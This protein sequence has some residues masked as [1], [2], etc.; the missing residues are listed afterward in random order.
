MPEP[1]GLSASLI[2][3]V[4]DAIGLDTPSPAMA[5]GVAEL[6]QLFT[7]ERQ[8]LDGSYLEDD[9]LRLG[10]LSY[11]LPVN[12]AKVQSLLDE[13]PADAFD[14]FP[15]ERPLT[16]LDV[17]SG[18][19][20]AALGVLDWM[21]T[22]FGP[23]KKRLEVLA[24]DRSPLALRDCQGLWEAY[25]KI[26]PMLGSRL[27]PVRMD[28][29]Q[30]AKLARLGKSLNRPSDLILLANCLNELCRGARD[31]VKALVKFLRVLL[32]LLDERGTLMVL[33]PALRSVSRRLHEVRDRLLAEGA[34]TVYSPCLHDRPCPALVKEDD[35]CHEDRPW[36]APPW[37]ARLDRLVGFRKDSLKFSYVL[38]RKDGRMLVPRAPTVFRVVSELRELKGEQR[39]WLCNE[40]GRPEVGRLDRDRSAA[41][42]AVEDWH[43]GAIVKIDQIAWKAAT[44]KREGLGRVTESSKVEIIRPI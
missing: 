24:V 28:L 12:L 3:V 8:G 32:D 25:G 19:G 36:I 17:G 16:V 2:R 5:R 34:C 37:V 43:R 1:R 4:A 15:P 10:Y 20:T 44:R 33:E 22:R 41:N 26:A 14:L 23:G 31:P 11:Y 7:S 21:A 40:T 18:P 42:A 35:W 29:R 13:L 6:S 39:A 30:G 9:G 38:L 27:V